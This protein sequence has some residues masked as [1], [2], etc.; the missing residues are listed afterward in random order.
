MSHPASRSAPFLCIGALELGAAGLLRTH[1]AVGLALATGLAWAGL[2]TAWV[3]VAYLLGRPD[4]L[5]K[6]R[7]WR[8]ALLPF[9]LAS[10]AV[11]RV[12]RR[13][14]V[15]ERSEVAPGLWVGGWPDAGSETWA[16]LDCT[17]ELPRRGR[18]EAY[19]CVPMLDGVAPGLERVSAAV[20]QAVRWRREGRTVLV[21]CAYGH[22]RSVIVACATMVIAGDAA[23]PDTAVRR[24][25][26]LRRG[27]RLAPAQRRALADA[28]RVLGASG[29]RDYDDPTLETT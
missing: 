12:A 1:G 9:T 14:G 13:V 24:V 23:D 21:H 16:Q 29:I 20:E 28:V 7:F 4:M 18:A 27:A 2:A 3:G 17:A 22:G 8:H 19:R 5:G 6:G 26:A 11:A 25:Q 15:S 10:A